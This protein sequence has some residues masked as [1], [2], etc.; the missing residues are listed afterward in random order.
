[1]ISVGYV[2]HYREMSNGPDYKHPQRALREGGTWRQLRH[3]HILPCIG[4]LEAVGNLFLVSPYIENGPVDQ[5]LRG[6]PKADRFKLVMC[7][8][9]CRGPFVA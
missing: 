2:E 4:V 1:M 9:L 5:Y 3:P 8:S 6:N 7:R